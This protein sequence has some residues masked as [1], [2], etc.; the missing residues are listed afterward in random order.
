MTAYVEWRLKVPAAEE[1]ALTAELWRCGSLGM[2][3]READGG[4]LMIAYFSDP[5]AV[6]DPP[7]DPSLW[8][9][10]GVEK[11][12]ESTFSE[13]DWMAAYRAQTAPLSTG[14]FVIHSGEPD[15]W[16]DESSAVVDGLQDDASYHLR[17]PA[18]TAFGTGSHESTRLTLAWLEALP[19]AGCR[20][21]DVG[22]GSGILA[23]AGMLLGAR[24]VVGYDIDS[25]SVCI[26]RTN[27][28]LN[29][30]LLGERVPAFFAGGPAAIRPGPLFDLA[31]VNVLPERILGHYPQIL[32]RLRPGGR[33]ISSGNLVSQRGDLLERFA[34]WGLRPEGEKIE[35]EW[36]A[37]ALSL[38]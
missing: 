5:P 1:E 19:L 8:E 15:A 24:Q 13:A 38:A 2:E 18:R 25:Q 7:F 9:Q 23:F 17:I 12:S 6:V 29:G 22:T 37:L 21:L 10:R 3:V 35:G 34:A 30:A 16:D 36:L 28:D 11:L 14:Q 26:A 27:I 31:V 32:E 33:V 4:K 20:L